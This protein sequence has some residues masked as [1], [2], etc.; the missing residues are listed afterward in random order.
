MTLTKTVIITGASSGMGA[1]TAELLAASGMKI[2]LAARREDRLQQL[3]ERIRQAGGIANYHVTDVTSLE[4]MQALA[5]A[6]LDTYGQ[7]DVMINNAGIMPISFIRKLKVDDW[8]R[9]I[10]VNIKGVLYGIAAVYPHM[11]AR[12]EGHII[13]FSSIAGHVTFPTSAIYSA[14]KHAVRIITEGLRVE[15]RPDQ[16]IRAT[17]ISPGAV[18]TELYKTVTDEEVVPAMDALGS[19]EW[20]QLD[21]QE[22]ANII[23]FAIEQ[24]A[25]TTINEIIVRP[26]SQSL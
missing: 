5:A 18:Q 7:I 1:A 8:D 21:A 10:D 15:S 16:H 14:T 24:P 17:L 20:K 9:M 3:T 6:T 2:M 25:S 19:A 23:K 11:E 12:K 22:I 13:N 4:Q 26:T